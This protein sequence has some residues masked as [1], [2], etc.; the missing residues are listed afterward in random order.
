MPIPPELVTYNTNRQTFAT[1]S[2]QRAAID[3]QLAALNTQKRTL[4]LAFVT[5]Y[6]PQD[7]TG[8]TEL[9]FL[10]A[11]NLSGVIVRLVGVNQLEIHQVS[12][13]NPLP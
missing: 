10:Q 13:S 8:P 12:A 5:K 4:E 11:N 9:L 1:L 6:F 7:Q 3:S 2:G